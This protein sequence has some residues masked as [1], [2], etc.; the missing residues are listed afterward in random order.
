MR[1]SHLLLLAGHM[2]ILS[3]CQPPAKPDKA[4]IKAEITQAEHAFRDSVNARGAEAAFVAFAAEE[5]TIRRENDTLIHGKAA[6]ARYHQTPFYKTAKAQWEPDFIDV[7][8]DGSMAYSYGRYRW[9]Y[10]DSSGQMQSFGGGYLTIWKRQAD[11]SWK[12]VWD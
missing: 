5:A 3:A 12:Y 9:D 7:A 2:L 10:P 4:Q 8:D 6:I 1:N 11:G